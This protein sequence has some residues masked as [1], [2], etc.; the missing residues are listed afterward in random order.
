[1]SSTVMFILLFG[2]MAFAYAGFALF[3]YGDRDPRFKRRY[4][5]P[6]LVIV[7]GLGVVLLTLH[8]PW[9]WILS[10]PL[11]GLMTRRQIRQTR[12]CDTCSRSS[13]DP[14]DRFCSRCG[15]RLDPRSRC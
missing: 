6:F 9:S 3:F 4:F 8:Q 5:G 11:F 12:F 15:D 13:M 7:S 2:W 10:I 14:G 1:M